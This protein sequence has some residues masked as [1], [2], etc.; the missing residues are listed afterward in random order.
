[1]KINIA[2]RTA[3]TLTTFIMF[4]LTNLCSIF[5]IISNV[6][7]YVKCKKIPAIFL[8]LMAGKN[9]LYNIFYLL[10]KLFL[11]S[12][13]IFSINLVFPFLYIMYMEIHQTQEKAKATII[14]KQNIKQLISFNNSLIT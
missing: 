9:Q 11:I 4:I 8:F 12:S 5:M 3:N 6:Y 13:G 14:T 2:Y 1:M 7:L 10:S